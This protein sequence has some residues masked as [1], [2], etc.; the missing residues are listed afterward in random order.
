[1]L[2]IHI[3]HKICINTTDIEVKTQTSFTTPC[4]IVF[5]FTE[6]QLW[7]SG[8]KVLPCSLEMVASIE[9]KKKYIYSVL[10]PEQMATDMVHTCT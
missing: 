1:M 10:N 6:L 5:L 2:Q 3:V 7:K 8:F 9:K 4:T